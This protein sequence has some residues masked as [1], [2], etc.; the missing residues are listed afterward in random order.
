MSLGIINPEPTTIEIDGTNWIIP[1]DRIY[2]ITIYE[3]NLVNISASNITL[4]QEYIEDTSNVYPRLVCNTGRVCYIQR[5]YN[6]YDYLN[7]V[8]TL[9]RNIPASNILIDPTN[10]L[11][12]TLIVVNI[13]SCLFFKN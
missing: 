1:Y 3:N 2:D 12:L 8:N 13:V 10:L 11:I 7:S 6:D 9:E 5:T 4:Y